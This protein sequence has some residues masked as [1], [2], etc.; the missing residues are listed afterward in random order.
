MNSPNRAEGSG[1]LRGNQR[2]RRGFGRGGALGCVVLL[3]I[4]STA[5]SVTKDVYVAPGALFSISKRPGEFTPAMGVELSVY[6]FLPEYRSVGGFAQWQ[7][8]KFDHHR[9]TAGVQA[10]FVIYGMELGATYETEGERGAP[11]TS[12]HIAPYI[13]IVFISAALR[14]GVPIR[15]GREDKPGHGYDVGLVLSFKYPWAIERRYE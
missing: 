9:F 5:A 10:A 7:M 2:G 12:L 6:T 14:V 3:L 4:P 13:S 1:T 11:T 15:G 8:V